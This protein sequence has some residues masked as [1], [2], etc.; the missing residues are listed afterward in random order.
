MN[1]QATTP[2]IERR[3]GT[4]GSADKTES[5]GERS[6]VAQA[7]SG[8]S[9]AFGELYERHRLRIYRTAFRILRNQQ[10]TEGE[11]QRSFQR[12]FT[13]LSRFRENSTFS[14]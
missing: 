14:T 3:E 8:G 12:E 2:L 11:A 1:V 7:K 6:L 13:N 5:T 10:D 4:C 9:S